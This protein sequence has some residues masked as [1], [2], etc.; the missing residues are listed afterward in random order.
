MML[1]GKKNKWNS[2]T[3]SFKKW[4]GWLNFHVM[5]YRQSWWLLS[6]LT[7][8]SLQCMYCHCCLFYIYVFLNGRVMLIGGVCQRGTGKQRTFTPSKR[9]TT[10]IFPPLLLQFFFSF[11][12]AI[13]C[14]TYQPDE[15]KQQRKRLKA[16]RLI[17]VPQQPG[18]DLAQWGLE[19]LA[20]SHFQH[21]CS[22]QLAPSRRSITA[23]TYQNEFKMK[24]CLT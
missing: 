2:I 14:Q 5:N 17:P 8:W 24:S 4:H 1:Y 15:C 20:P 11:F 16:S 10:V 18:P 23:S 9:D 6:A 3:K 12:I 21:V 7:N 22:P 13:Y 19:S